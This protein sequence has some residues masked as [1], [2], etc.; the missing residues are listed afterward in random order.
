MLFLFFIDKIYIFDNKNTKYE[1]NYTISNFLVD[2]D[3]LSAISAIFQIDTFEK[4]NYN[5]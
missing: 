2:F 3:F 4:S 1:E 5:S